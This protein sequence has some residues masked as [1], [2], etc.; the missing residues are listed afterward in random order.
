[1]FKNMKLGA[2]IVTG[3]T[4][5]VAIAVAL[6]GLAIWSMSSVSSASTMLAEEYAPEAKFCNEL[7][8]SSLL[9]MYAMRGYALSEN[10]KYWDQGQDG[11]NNVEESLGKCE[12]LAQESENLDKLREAVPKTQAAVQR[13]KELADQTKSLVDK[14]DQNRADLDA[15]AQKYMTN[16]TEFIKGQNEAFKKDLAERQKKIS[17]VTDIVAVGTKTRVLNFKSQ[18]T[19]KPEFMREAISTIEGVYRFTRDLREIT[20]DKEDIRRIDATE[21]AAK[22]YKEA[23]A[24]FLDEY[25]K[26][27]NA[28]QAVLARCREEMDANAGTYVSNCD[29]FLTDQQAK[30]TTDMK[31]RHEKITLVNDIIDLGNATRIAC[32]KSQAMRDPEIIRQA[33]DNFEKMKIKYEALRKITRLPE[34]LQ[35][36]DNT[37]QAGTSYKTAMNSLLD[38]WL[39]LQTTSVE[40][41]KAADEV[42]AQAQG[43][44]QAALEETLNISTGA[45]EDLTTATMTLIVGLS[46]A[47]IVSVLMA[48][49]ITKSITGPIRRIIEGLSIGSDQTAEA[50]GQVSSASQGLAEGASEAAASIEETS[51]SIEEMSSMTKQN[52]T[53]SDEAN[54]L[55][56]HARESADRGTEAMGRMSA[57]IDDIKQSSDETAK[58]VKTIDEIAFQTNLLALNAAVEA[59]R[60]G[61]AGKGFAVVA[62][63]VRNL[64]QRAGEAARNTSDLIEGSVSKSDNGVAISQEVA[65]ALGE[66]AEGSRKVN[67]LVSE[68]SA[69]SNEQS[70]GIDQVS[71]A[72]TQLDQV[73]QSNAANAEECASAAEELSSQAEEMNK[74]VAELRNMVGGSEAGQQ[75]QQKKQGRSFKA[76]KAPAQQAQ[77]KRQAQPQTQQNQEQDFSLESDEAEI[78]K[79]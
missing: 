40:R 58:I 7:E 42:L 10:K 39:K 16:C 12:K 66:I 34:D 33:N 1:M 44:A 6:G 69:A 73:T 38:N 79:F 62:E 23:M 48:V 32:F 50:S 75:P 70:S 25:L 8:R 17:L 76:S 35:R 72:V 67:D 71:T 45:S 5:L 24:K 52:A 28:D 74:M 43:A 46:I 53:N 36:I 65:A 47:V 15:G 51:S 2:K 68:I 61:E 20:R 31:E 63:E 9:T 57:A 22:G 3:F 55:A 21:A 64:A 4:V 37:E 49:F 41:G 29:S 18:A 30:L 77:P 13:Y 56:A 60:A 59:A 54:K 14:L 26:G 19:G 78:S 27:E 11:L